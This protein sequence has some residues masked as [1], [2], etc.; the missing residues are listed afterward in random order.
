M[1]TVLEN[2]FS[3]SR[4]KAVSLVFIILF[5]AFPLVINAEE[6]SIDDY[7]TDNV[8]QLFLGETKL[9]TVKKPRRIVVG[10]PSIIDVSKASEDTIILVTK[11]VGMTTFIFWDVFG[12]HPYRIRVLTEDMTEAKR[13]VDKLIAELKLKEVYTKANDEEGKVLLLGYVRNQAEKD[14]IDSAL[15]VLKKKTIDLIQIKD[16]G[17]V[18]IEAR[19]LELDKDASRT[20]GFDLPGALTMT[21]W[22]GPTQASGPE[23]AFTGYGGAFHISDWGRSALTH[24]LSFLVQ[25]GKAR[26][27][28]QPKLAC[29]SGKEA[30]LLVGGE[31]PIFT[32]AVQATAGASTTVEYKEYGI[33]LNIKPTIMDKNR[34]NVVLNIEVSEIGSAETIGDPNAPSAKAYPLQKRNIST[35]L[36]LN[37]GQTLAI[38][39]LI[40]SKKE[41]DIKRTA[42]L[43]EIPIIGALFRKKTTKWG[44]GQG[45]RGDVELFITLTPSI[46]STS[47]ASI[48]NILLPQTSSEIKGNLSDNL[49]AYIRN[50]Q[51]KII[52]AAYYPP[53]ARELGW[54]G[55]VKLSLLVLSDGELKEAIISQSSGYKI[56]DEAA[57]D[58]VLRQAP[59]PSFPSRVEARELKIEV[60]ITYRRDN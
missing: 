50:L 34:I 9:F 36:F 48:E 44:G 5:I 28:S 16:E 3:K 24:T 27:L 20:L 46:V 57:L 11:A 55:T 10:N 42:G 31:K 54:E 35:E 56:L 2:L 52:N 58:A 59:F 18:E 43:S 25:E 1:L 19:V 33:K 39:G 41:E 22:S 47:E 12:E 40:K 60:P 23:T 26:I 4:K 8:E 45:E 38:G 49:K 7:D 37:D 13:R 17:V 21:E 53:D 29:L 6:F 14:R 51:S 15:D 30:E 32:T